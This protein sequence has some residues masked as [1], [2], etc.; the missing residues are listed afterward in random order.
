MT[1]NKLKTTLSSLNFLA[2][3]KLLRRKMRM[4]YL[5]SRLNTKNK[6]KSLASKLP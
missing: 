5:I 3:P 6:L 4:N 1:A 2:Q